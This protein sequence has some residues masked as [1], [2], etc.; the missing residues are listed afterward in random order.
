MDLNE[1]L[2]EELAEQVQG[3]LNED[4]ELMVNDGSYIPRDRLN[5]KNEK[6]ET[7]E[8]RI[9]EYDEQLEELKEDSQTSGGLKKRIE[10]LQ[11]ENR[12]VQQQLTEEKIEKELVR[13][14]A[15]EPVAVKALLDRE[16]I[17]VGDGE[18][19]GLQK[20]L[21][22][23]KEEKDFLFDTGTPNKAGSDGF[24]GDDDG[25]A[26]TAQ[27]IENMSDEE[28]NENWDQVQEFLQQQGG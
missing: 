17:E 25:V 11:D 8:Q 10:K 13:A 15:R 24:G 22:N 5:D 20:Q 12:Q 14:G 9:K 28:I 16:Q 23:L 3:Q 2:G 19:K 26:L 4:Q 18:V 7:L 27:Q 21:E 6:I 1:L